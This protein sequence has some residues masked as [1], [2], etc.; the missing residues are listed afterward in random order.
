MNAV[1]YERKDRMDREPRASEYR[2]EGFYVRGKIKGH[3]DD[4]ADE[5]C[6]NAPAGQ[7]EYCYRDPHPGTE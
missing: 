2:D 1:A 6:D 3:Y 5:W 7:C 4:Q